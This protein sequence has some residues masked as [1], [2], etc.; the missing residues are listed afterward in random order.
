MTVLEVL[1]LVLLAA[2]VGAISQAMAGY[3]RGGC[4]V[5]IALGFIGALLGTWIARMLGL[6]ELFVL[7]V[8][9]QPFPVIWSI[10]GATLFV[11]LLG[12]LS[13]SRRRDKTERG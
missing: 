8:G 12:L 3:S 2:A 6:P 13:R 10:I 9:D 5:T 1:V 4:L 7:Y 11:S